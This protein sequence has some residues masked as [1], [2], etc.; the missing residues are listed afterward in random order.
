M[1]H[2]L[3]CIAAA[4][5]RQLS[6]RLKSRRNAIV[7]R[8]E[9]DRNKYSQSPPLHE[10]G[11]TDT[12][13]NGTGFA[14]PPSPPGGFVAVN[15][16]RPAEAGDEHPSL[17][18]QFMLNHPNTDNITIINGTN[19]KGASPTTRAELLKKFLTTA[20][21]AGRSGQPEAEGSSSL[22]RQSSR[23]GP[24][25]SEASEM[26]PV[27][28]NNSTGT[29]AIPNTP[30]S[31]LPQPKS[32]NYHE[33]DD[34]G[35]FKLEMVARMEDLQRGERILPPCDR[36]RRLHMDCLKNLTACM[37]CTKK[38]AKCSWKD[39]KEEELRDLQ[40][41]QPRA[42]VDEQRDFARPAAPD[43]N[44]HQDE[45]GADHSHPHHSSNVYSHDNHVEPHPNPHNALVL[46]QSEPPSHP[47]SQHPAPR[48]HA[49]APRRANSDVHVM[50][51]HDQH[52]DSH[53]QHHHHPQHQQH[54]QPQPQPQHQHQP[55]HDRRSSFHH[56]NILHDNNSINNS[57]PHHRNNHHRNETDN[58]PDANSRLMQA[59]KDTVDHHSTRV[60][61]HIRDGE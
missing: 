47:Y 43:S 32:V 31:L 18:S 38:H 20:D 45:H 19:I 15:A 50:L 60:Q 11:S 13:V 1:D 23:T 39:V 41:R 61:K 12:A 9:N 33:R 55:Q 17:S 36:C 40:P 46:A 58:D 3:I 14:N 34:G 8:R 28:F 22:T 49:T 53:H 29:V 56:R 37:G 48:E 27:M 44:N 52:T 51:N 2:K 7:T 4:R 16:G 54:Q 10:H 26:P 6:Y 57:N 24:R 30:P 5:A 59:I 25:R 35:P 42:H 21:R